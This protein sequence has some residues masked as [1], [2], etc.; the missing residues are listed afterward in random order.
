MVI[1]AGLA[2]RFMQIPRASL[3]H[4][5]VC[6]LYAP[7]LP[8]PCAG[9]AAA[10][11]LLQV[12]RFQDSGPS[13]GRILGIL[14]RDGRAVQGHQEEPGGDGRPALAQGTERWALLEGVSMKRAS[15]LHSEGTQHRVMREPE[16]P[17]KG[18]LHGMVCQRDGWDHG[19]NTAGTWGPAGHRPDPW[20]KPEPSVSVTNF[21]KKI[22][23][24]SINTMKFKPAAD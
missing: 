4:L 17:C 16:H 24:R 12:N 2:S 1:S 15:G 20:L 3:Q 5:A 19:T 8:E 7:A 11:P 22:Y 23:F 21:K 14:R 9:F 10:L 13:G 18:C 6:C